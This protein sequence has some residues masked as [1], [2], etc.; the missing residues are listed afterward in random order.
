MQ[1]LEL[2]RKQSPEILVTGVMS[3]RSSTTSALQC[4]CPSVLALLG[5]GA[6]AL[7]F[8]ILYFTLPTLNGSI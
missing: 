4:S 6:T 3:N 8:I 7:I 1:L 5:S 2:I